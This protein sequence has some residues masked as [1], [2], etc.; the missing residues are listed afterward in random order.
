[1]G[2]K[3]ICQWVVV[4]NTLLCSSLWPTG[5][6]VLCFCMSHAPLLLNMHTLCQLCTHPG[7]SLTGH[8]LKETLPALLRDTLRVYVSG[9]CFSFSSQDREVFLTHYWLNIAQRITVLVSHGRGCLRNGR[10]YHLV[11]LA[12]Y[13]CL[14]M[15]GCTNICWECNEVRS[16]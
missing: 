8:P 6:G 2:A 13:V 15:C 10:S 4:I 7:S 1:M 9:A 14:S 12:G 5:I 16:N 3:E 11:R